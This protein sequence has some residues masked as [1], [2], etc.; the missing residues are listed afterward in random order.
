MNNLSKLNQEHQLL[1][2]NQKTQKGYN[3][4]N[5]FKG[6][7]GQGIHIIGDALIESMKKNQRINN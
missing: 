6:K 2:K 5:K 7:K 3:S 4:Y 1:N